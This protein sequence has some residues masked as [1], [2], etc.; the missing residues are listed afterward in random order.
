[1]E[2]E[3]GQPCSVL[4]GTKNTALF[5]YVAKDE[6]HAIGQLLGTALLGERRQRLEL[7]RVPQRHTRKPPKGRERGR[8][9]QNCCPSFAVFYEATTEGQQSDDGHFSSPQHKSVNYP[10]SL[11]DLRCRIRNGSL[12]ITENQDE[13]TGCQQ[14][15]DNS[16]CHL[17]SS[18]SFQPPET[19]AHI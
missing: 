14:I 8:L 10:A 7:Q 13:S 5:P 12:I 18:T 17:A 2:V 4:P 11:V 15:R 3:A 9:S 19:T 16:V 1:M 6:V